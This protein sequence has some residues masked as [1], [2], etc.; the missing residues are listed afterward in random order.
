VTRH[1]VREMRRAGLR[2]LVADDNATNREVALGILRK[3]GLSAHPVENGRQALDAL[4]AEDFDLVLLDVQMPEMDG[5]EAARR[6]RDRSSPVR[7][8]DV[9]IVAMTANAFAGDRARCL[10]AGMNDYLTKP[11]SARG[12]AEAVERWLPHDGE[13]S[14]AGEAA[15]TSVQA[16]T[17]SAESGGAVFDRTSLEQRLLGDEDLVRSIVNGFLSDIPA[18]LALLEQGLNA[19]DA[20]ES[21]RL[22]HAIK[23]A[24]ASVGGEALRQAAAE[25]ERL[26]RAGQMDAMRQRLQ[27]LKARMASLA[28]AM[29][30]TPAGEASGRM[31]ASKPTKGAL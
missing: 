31:G 15:R 25:M 16:P 12:L 1:T 13:R 21:I 10:E 30:A 24:A 27:P 17:L 7:R 14:S 2:I 22:A 28:A 6:I 3:I 4:A 19:A 18:Q 8:H 5:Y 23:G 26:G 29:Q 9:P 20:D 11:V